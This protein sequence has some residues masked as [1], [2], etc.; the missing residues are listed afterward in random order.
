MLFSGAFFE[1]VTLKGTLSSVNSRIHERSKL[2]DEAHL[3]L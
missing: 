2:F 3:S 1:S